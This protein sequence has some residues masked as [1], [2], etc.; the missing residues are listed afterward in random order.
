MATYSN[1]KGRKEG[2]KGKWNRG[3]YRRGE[4]NRVKKWVK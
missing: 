2:I 4:R 1:Q 3:R